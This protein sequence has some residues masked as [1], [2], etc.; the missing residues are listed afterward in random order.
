MANRETGRW[1]ALLIASFVAQT[2]FIVNSTETA[3]WNDQGRMGAVLSQQ[4]ADTAAPLALSRDMVSLSV[5]ASRYEN[6]PGIDSVRLFN[7]RQELIAETGDTRDSGRLFTAPMNLQQQALGRVELR[8][9]VP[10]RGQIVRANLGNISLSALLH[11]LIFISGFFVGAR[12]ERPQGRQ[13]AT[14]AGA[15][16][17]AP[18]ASGLAAAERP[19][20]SGIT[21]LHIA[22]DDPNSLLTRVNAAMADEL[23][24][25]FDQF[26]DRAARLY[27][28][29][30][31]SPFSP[32]GVL[33]SFSQADPLEREFQALAAAALFLQLVQDSAEERRQHGRL[34]L[35]A[36]AGL[37]HGEHDS[38]TAAVLAHTAPSGRILGTLPQSVLGTR[39]RLG[40]PFQ[41]AVS[42]TQAIQAAL[43]EEFA[44]E[45]RQLISNQSQQILGPL[46]IS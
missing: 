46:E 19:S 41:L 17:S 35:G 3:L 26:I 27:G 22:L 31:S 33:V 7:A 42:S 38:H 21:L 14:A 6:R 24:G 18:A 11:A 10:Q 32:E 1:A 4:L 9:G 2:A 23:L 13:P 43:L 34:C 45:Y 8:L 15:A 37:L 16:S 36:K 28:G 29:E 39:C 12:P 20:A 30:V 40:A 25:V 5:L 44:P